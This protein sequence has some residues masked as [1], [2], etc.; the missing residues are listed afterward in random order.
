[1][2][3]EIRVGR[4]Q[5]PMQRQDMPMQGDMSGQKSGS[6]MPWVILGIVVVVLIVLGVLFRGSLFKGKGDALK[7]SDTAGKAS[8]YEAVFL[9]NGQVYFGKLSDAYGEYVTL[10]DI[11][12]LQVGPAQGSGAATSSPQNI[13]LV[14][15]GQELHGPTDE[16]HISRAQILFYEDL[17]NEGNVVSAILKDKADK[18]ATPAK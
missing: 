9:T 5:Q 14:K 2:S 15:L 10:K 17:K 3:D 8:G 7:S 1:M 16:M 11:Y 18:A 6:K 4:P 12:Y 13:Q